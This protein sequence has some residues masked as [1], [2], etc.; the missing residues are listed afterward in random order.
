MADGVETPIVR[1]LL[2]ELE[3]LRVRS[4]RAV[5]PESVRLTTGQDGEAMLTFDIQT[6]PTAEPSSVDVRDVETVHFVYAGG[7]RFGAT[8]PRNVLCDR[9]DFPRNVG[10]LCSGPPGCA[11]APCL[12]LGGM[13]P[14][15]ERGGIEALLERLRTFM[16]DAKTG[17][18]MADGWEPVPFGFQQQFRFGQVQPKFFQE[19]AQAH[20]QGGHAFGVAINREDD[21]DRAVLLVPGAVSI[22]HIREALGLQCDGAK[23]RGVP[24][25]FLWRDPSVVETDPI[26][27][28]WRTE[29]EMRAGLEQVGVL[30][31]YDTAVG[32]LLGAGCDFAHHHEHG[33]KSVVVVVGIWRP[34]PIMDSF[35]GYSDDPRARRL[36]LRALIV[37]WPSVQTLPVAEAEVRTVIGDHPP[38]PELFRWVSGAPMLPPIALLGV[39]ALGGSIL[40]NLVRSGASDLLLQDQDNLR[41]HN[42]TRNIARISDG[43]RKKVMQASGLVS[44]ISGADCVTHDED[45]VVTPSEVMAGRLRGRLVVDATADERVRVALDDRAV[46]GDCT[47]VRSEIFHDGRLGVTFVSRPNGP[48]LADLLVSLY[49]SA[50]EDANIAAWLDHENQYPL[51]P[52]PLL[53]GFGCTSQT[54]RLPN[55]WVEQHASV[56]AAMIFTPDEG[57]G[58]ALNPVDA[59]GLPSGWSWR[60]VAPFRELK[61]PTEPE[62]TVRLSEDVAAQLAERREA[63]LPAE[64]GGYLYGAWDPMRKVITIVFAGEQPP[65]T[66]ADDVSLKLGP[67]GATASERRL[68]RKTRGRLY[69]CGSW[70]SHPDG[71]AG[72]S[73]RDYKTMM[74]CH[75]IDEPLRRPTLMV[76]VADGDLQAHLRIG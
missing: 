5:V 8:A 10:H 43:Y 56:T 49:A 27:A 48:N 45:I 58:V 20:P 33:R 25:V 42:L 36:E 15:Y 47:I 50:T 69:L 59:R 66:T 75:E 24:W 4:S 40:N 67:A 34:A 7:A 21:V 31:A 53:Y 68:D 51:G 1:D 46:R 19:H 71:A 52:D 70:H 16:R 63:A 64:T 62:W 35:F 2:H 28:D 22:E 26:F 30:Q 57:S 29:A 39:G 65:D 3:L 41:A 12:A 14:I 37:S 55:H 73:G 9:D 18:L 38:E 17:S 13:Q 72:L 11:A 61:P 54:T 6:E 23:R 74:A 60:P 44:D 76:I 32:E